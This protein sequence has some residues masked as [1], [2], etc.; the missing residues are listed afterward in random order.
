[1]KILFV[2]K[3]LAAGPGGGAERVLATISGALAER[4][5]EVSILTFDAPGSEDFYRT[6]PNVARIQIGIGNTMARSQPV[7]TAARLRQVRKEAKR[8]RPDVAVGFMHSSFVPLAIALVGT[9][10][11]VVGSEHTSYPHYLLHPRVNAMVRLTLPLLARVTVPA[12]GVR[13]GY[14][15]MIRRR[16][17]VL[18]NPVMQVAGK[19][20]S[21]GGLQKTL[22]TVGGL[23]PE[24]N[25]NTLIRAFARLKDTHPDW[26]LRIVGSGALRAPLERLAGELGV[27]VVFAGTTDDVG[28]EYLNAQLFVL[29]SLY[30]AFPLALTEALA[31]GLPAVGFSDCPGTNE[32]IQHGVNGLLVEPGPRVENLAMALAELMSAPEKRR[33]FGMAALDVGSRFCLDDI[34]SQWEELLR[35]VTAAP[36]TLDSK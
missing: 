17:T 2:T 12:P 35:L 1:M 15:G 14:P 23:R 26:I 10:I 22:L 36:D 19:A 24:K 9:G 11:P 20:D 27:S 33:S 4:G 16:L 7:V 32:L 21:L 18:H 6:G 30:E 29:P 34:V 25:Q 3:A 31:H 13:E 28:R 8:L 5:H